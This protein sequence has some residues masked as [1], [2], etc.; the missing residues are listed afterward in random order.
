MAPIPKI[1]TMK[2]NLKP[3]NFNQ[4]AEVEDGLHSETHEG[5]FRIVVWNLFIANL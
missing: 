5:T 4:P 3:N 2:P 1:S